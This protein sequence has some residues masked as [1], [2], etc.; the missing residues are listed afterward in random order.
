MRT[1]N[2]PYKFDLSKGFFKTGS[3]AT[4]EGGAEFA[5]EKRGKFYLIRR[6]A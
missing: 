5:A 2:L 1:E 6:Q 3:L 4:F